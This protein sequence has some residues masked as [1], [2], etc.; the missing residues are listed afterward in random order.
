MSDPD[1]K[2]LFLSENLHVF[3]RFGP[4]PASD[5][6]VV[7]WSNWVPVQSLTGDVFGE[8]VF[9][10]NGIDGIYVNCASNAWWQYPELP[11]ALSLVRE[12]AAGRPIVTYGSSMGG[13]AAIRFS[14]ALDAVRAVAVA[15]Q[16]S[17]RAA[18]V[19][20]EDRWDKEAVCITYIYEDEPSFTN[21]C[22]TYVLYDPLYN[23]D[24]QHVVAYGALTD[25]ERVELYCSGHP[26]L[27]SLVEY[28]LASWFALSAVKG[29]LDR[30]YLRSVV[31][32]RRRSSARYWREL[33][34]RCMERGHHRWA[35]QA[36]AAGSAL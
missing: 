4:E 30:T 11:E 36:R 32:A 10:Q 21:S 26:P 19:P 7:C 14:K 2:T 31:R 20:G 22:E 15:P 33:S 34:F 35:D 8:G 6:V 12:A 23:K 3:S 1:R 13:Y 29:Q 28:G 5:V 24:A 17:I 18:V 9:P 25:L 27:D 16:F